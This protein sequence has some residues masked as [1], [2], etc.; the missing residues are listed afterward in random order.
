MAEHNEFG[1]EGEDIAVRWLGKKE[2]EILFRNWRSGHLEIDI[3]AQKAACLHFIEVKTRRNDDF[4][5]P[6]KFVT[7]QKLNNLMRAAAVFQLRY[8]HPLDVQY[9]ILAI[10]IGSNGIPDFFFVEDVY[11]W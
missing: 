2:F 3:I 9:D 10:T 8:P 7:R 4:G 1:K 11:W 6:E 5:P